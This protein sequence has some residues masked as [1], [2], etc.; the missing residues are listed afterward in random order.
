MPKWIH[1][2]IEKSCARHTPTIASFM[3]DEIEKQ[4]SLVEFQK[5][6]CRKLWLEIKFLSFFDLIRICRY[7]ATI[8]S[9]KEKINQ[10]KNERNL[11]LLRLR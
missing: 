11:I 8:G 5:K 1:D 3:Q 10:Q 4:L 2:S 6:N 9:S 7:I